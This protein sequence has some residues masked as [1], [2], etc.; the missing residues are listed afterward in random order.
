MAYEPFPAFADWKVDFDPSLVEGYSARLRQAKEAATSEAQRHALRVATRYAAVDTGAIEGLY[1]TDRGFTK[2]IATQSEFWQRALD[3]KGEQ[4]KR[5]IEDALAGYDYV[6][7]AVTG[8]A[9]LTTKW[10]RELHAVITKHQE[11]YPVYVPGADGFVEDQRPL[12]HGEYKQYPNNPT[13]ASTGRVHYYAPPEGTPAEM[14]RLID[15]LNSGAFRHAHPIVQATY[16]HYAYICVH[17]FAD[18]NGRVAR[19]LASVYLYRDPGVPLVIFADQRDLYIDALEAADAGRPSPFVQFLAQRVIDTVNMVVDSLELHDEDD[20]DIATIAQAIQAWPGEELVL[21]AKRLQ[22]AC[23][24][25]LA[26]ELATKNLPGLL[27]VTVDGGN[28]GSIPVPAGYVIA[29]PFA[30]I[31]VSAEIDQSSQQ[32]HYFSHVVA[33][34]T[35][36][37]RPELL[38]VPH[39]SEGVPLEVWLREIDP[40]ETTSLGVRLDTWAQNVVHRFIKHLRIA[41]APGRPD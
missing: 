36:P 15:E 31:N 33:V 27:G 4:V 40:M 10:I 18:G 16:A 3:L 14:T 7:D 1:T 12:L 6:L 26:D 39:D 22:N 37:N 9:P 30:W 19:A 32:R 23:A 21:A 24:S 25:C 41:L 38:V 8:E 13:S 20:T 2:T 28:M 17:P 35:E 29:G 34:T 5:S 11:T